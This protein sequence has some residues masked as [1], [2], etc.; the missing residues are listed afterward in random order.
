M[1]FTQWRVASPCNGTRGTDRDWR[2]VQPALDAVR[3]AKERRPDESVLATD[4]GGHRP[5]LFSL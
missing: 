1:Y 4:H 2:L 3:T 5:R